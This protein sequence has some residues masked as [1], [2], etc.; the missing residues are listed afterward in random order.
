MPEVP[1][2][3]TSEQRQAALA[4][5]NEIRRLRASLKR[6]I[7][8]GGTTVR[9][10]LADPPPYVSTSKVTDLLVAVPGVGHVRAVRLLKRCAIS[11]SKTVGG[12]TERQRS[13]LLDLL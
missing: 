10:V 3:R 8:G 7:R 4:Q 5:A 2:S 12:L 9:A 1:P 6:D 11:E 13:A